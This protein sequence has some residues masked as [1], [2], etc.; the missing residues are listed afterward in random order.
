MSGTQALLT[1]YAKAG[2]ERAFRELVSSYV[3]FVFSTA[4]RI[5]GG[6]RPLAEDVAQAVFTDLAQKARSL[7]KDVR[8]GGWLHRHTCFLARK[9]LRRERRR[10]AREK[11]AIEL[12]SIEDYSEANLAQ[13]ALV[14]DEVIDDLGEEDR[15]AIVLRFFEELDYRSI[16]E[17]LG[18]SEDA[19]RMRVS[20]AIDKMGAL[21]KRRGIVLTAAGISFV[22]SGKLATAAPS[23]LATRI[24]Y[25]EL[26][27]PA[28]A[29]G[30]FGIIREACFTRLNVGLV[31][32]A[33]ILAL[34][35]LLISGRHTRAKTLPGPDAKTFAPA[36]FADLG[37]EEP[38]SQDTAETTVAPT[39]PQLS[40]APSV[41]PARIVAPVQAVPVKPVVANVP[42][43]Q[44]PPIAPQSS[45]E[46]TVPMEN[47]S[48][49]QAAANAQAYANANSWRQ[50]PGA[51]FPP[52][53][54]PQTP[55]PKAATNNSSAT[56][57]RTP[58]NFDTP[59]GPWAP[60]RTT[61]AS[62][63]GTMSPNASTASANQS[64]VQPVRPAQRSAPSSRSN[65]PRK[66]D[67][68]L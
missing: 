60:I 2:S 46:A 59:T 20:R 27:R 4:L 68:Q 50:R 32:A 67:R 21:L 53:V 43:A 28:K 16:G 38:D 17:A 24:V 22:L 6:D 5:V 64:S 25:A 52:Q 51:Y 40:P 34:L 30:I 9:S 49:V 56:L 10:I 26:V 66:R 61:A 37:V 63:P 57:V 33:V 65:D 18:S 14:L 36:E 29:Q 8:L 55:A 44:P 11:R 42:R 19:A 7:P 13:M 35:V 15:N 39:E 1:E 3:N 47:G 41:A 62:E 31:S 45:P 54:A 48:G 12:H 58:P 23:G